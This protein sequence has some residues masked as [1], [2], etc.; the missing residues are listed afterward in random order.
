M[1]QLPPHE[2]RVDQGLKPGD[3]QGLSRGAGRIDRGR[4]DSNGFWEED[5]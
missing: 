5:L 2:V 1:T 3:L 4:F